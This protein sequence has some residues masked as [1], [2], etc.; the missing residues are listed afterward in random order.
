VTHLAEVQRPPVMAVAEQ[1]VASGRADGDSWAR[2]LRRAD[3]HLLAGWAG[4]PTDQLH[5]WIQMVEQAQREGA[6]FHPTDQIVLNCL[7]NNADLSWRGD[8]LAGRHRGGQ[9]DLAA[10]VGVVGK[11][12]GRSLRRLAAAGWVVH[13]REH[14]RGMSG[15]W[16]C[17]VPLQHLDGTST[18]LAGPTHSAW[19]TGPMKTPSVPTAPEQ[20]LPAA[21]VAPTAPAGPP[22]RWAG[23]RWVDIPV[24]SSHSTTSVDG[25]EV[26]W[27]DTDGLSSTGL[28]AAGAW[29]DTVVPDGWTSDVRPPVGVPTPRTPPSVP[30]QPRQIPMVTEVA[31]EEETCSAGPPND[32]WAAERALVADAIAGRP[33]SE[34]APGE[35]SGQTLEA[36][37]AAA[38]AAGTRWVMAWLNTMPSAKSNLAGLIRS[39]VDTRLSE[40]LAAEMRRQG[41]AGARPVVPDVDLG[42]YEAAYAVWEAQVAEAWAALSESDRAA[43]DV[44]IIESRFGPTRKRHVTM[45]E[46][47]EAMTGQPA[48]PSPED[49]AEATLGQVVDPDLRARAE[50]LMAHHR[51][52]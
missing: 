35:L 16:Y 2:L 20:D 14:R 5:D 13:L 31:A 49:L 32:L 41:A 38:A 36:I 21:P 50:T 12:I 34:D 43:V 28:P 11:T 6:G 23:P 51:A 39:H 37:G 26:A 52:A 24:L 22:P 33:G 44:G 19:Q 30:R 47:A 48:P 10:R 4:M 17:A 40:A 27:G 46:R 25:L 7:R 42:A 45:W 29:G 3:D 1:L 8:R 18:V 15:E 9:K